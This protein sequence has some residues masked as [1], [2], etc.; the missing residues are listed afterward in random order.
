MGEKI[1]N[2]SSIAGSNLMCFVEM[3]YLIKTLGR[4]L[5][6]QGLY[7]NICFDRKLNVLGY[8]LYPYRNIVS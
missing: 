2:I 3:T 1:S 4:S 7:E 6:R 8:T 5:T